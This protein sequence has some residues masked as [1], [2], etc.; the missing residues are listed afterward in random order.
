MSV[1]VSSLKRMTMLG[2]WGAAGHTGPQTDGVRT[3]PLGRR[4]LDGRFRAQTDGR[5]RFED[6][7]FACCGSASIRLDPLMTTQ[8]R[9]RIMLVRLGRVLPT[10]APCTVA[11]ALPVTCQRSEC[12]RDA[13]VDYLLEKLQSRQAAER[14]LDELD[15][16]IGVLEELPESFPRTGPLSRRPRFAKGSLHELPRAVSRG[17]GH[18]IPHAHLPP[19]AGLR[20]LCVSAGKGFGLPLSEISGKG[21]GNFK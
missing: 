5:C 14:F 7:G 20:A 12:D 6:G 4:L 3:P 16:L 10:A 2:R 19:V 15:R 8:L 1:V 17:G 21:D 13:I 11:R 9:S 18:R